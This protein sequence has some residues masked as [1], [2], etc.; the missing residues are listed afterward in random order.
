V[1]GR[2]FPGVDRTFDRSRDSTSAGRRYAKDLK[3]RSAHI[4]NNKCV[5]HFCAALNFTKIKMRVID[6]KSR[7]ILSDLRFV[8]IWAIRE[9][10]RGGNG[11]RAAVDSLKHLRLD[12]YANKYANGHEKKM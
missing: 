5:R 9:Y 2:L 6:I 8:W 11:S 1:D 10:V 12:E 3:R 7:R 4:A